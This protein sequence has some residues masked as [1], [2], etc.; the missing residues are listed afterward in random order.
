MVNEPRAFT[1]CVGSCDAIVMFVCCLKSDV[2]V[3]YHIHWFRL[4]DCSDVVLELF[5]KWLS[6]LL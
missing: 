6:D 5:P 4:W 3:A 1:V 2:E